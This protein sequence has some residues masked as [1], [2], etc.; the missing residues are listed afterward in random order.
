MALE[1]ATTIIY[2]DGSVEFISLNPGQVR[3]SILGNYP[4]GNPMLGAV[5]GIENDYK[6]A[7]ANL[8]INLQKEL[9]VLS[10]QFPPLT[11]TAAIAGLQR[12]VAVINS[13]MV[14]KNSELQTELKAVKSSRSIGKLMATYNAKLLNEQ[15]ASLLARVGK[16]DAEIT[17]QQQ[18]NDAKAEVDYK[19]A[20]K[21]TAD[22]YKELTSKVGGQLATEAQA[23]AA[24]VQGKRIG[25]AK[26]AMAAY[27][28][29][30]DALNKKF[31]AKDREA[32]AKALDSLNKE[33]LAKNLEQF[34]KAFGYVGKA[35]DYADLLVEIKKGYATGEW[36]STFLK[37]ETLLAGNAAGALLAFAFG[38]AASTVMGAIAFAMIMAVT[39]A[40]ID[41]A[42]VKK[43]N[44]ALLAL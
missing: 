17:R 40:Y 26:E 23:L 11:D 34:S 9:D 42:R 41:E 7:H 5:I 27:E 1:L 21:F 33:Q 39:S 43:F 12:Q 25:N 8:E 36:G 20:V 28:Q 19:A 6:A 24:G 2:G 3:G 44:D 35:M 16:L 10:S 37:I 4:M 13:L 29:Y 18:A 14:R 30:K 15:V 31:S 38:V 22:F 32:I